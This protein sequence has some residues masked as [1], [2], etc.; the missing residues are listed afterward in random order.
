MFKIYIYSTLLLICYIIYKYISKTIKKYYKSKETVYKLDE[1]EIYK[2]IN[3]NLLLPSEV[4]YLYWSGGFSSTFRLCQLLLI[5]EKPVQTIYVYNNS[6]QMKNELKALKNIRKLIISNYPILKQKFLPTR[7]ITNIKNNNS[8]NNKYNILHNKYGNFKNL[9]KQN[10]ILEKLI[11]YSLECDYLIEICIDNNNE[12]F[13]NNN[14]TNSFYNNLENYNYKNHKKIIKNPNP[15]EFEIMNNLVF[16][17]IIYNKKQLNENSIINI[18]NY[19]LQLCWS[20]E[21]QVNLT[22]CKLCYKCINSPIFI[23]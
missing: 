10:N 7:Y 5:E 4:I 19:I 3:Y 21:N 17:V 16:P 1:S 13:L 20:C 14:K 8:S 22:R 12:E 23:P 9:T 6:I 11:R 18:F 2:D 15:S